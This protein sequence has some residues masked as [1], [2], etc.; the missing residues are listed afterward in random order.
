MWSHLT[1]QP[2]SISLHWLVDTQPPS[3]LSGDG[4]HVYCP[5]P[6]WNMMLLV[7]YE[8]C[9][10]MVLK[11]IKCDFSFALPWSGAFHTYLRINPPRTDTPSNTKVTRCSFPLSF[12]RKYRCKYWGKCTVIKILWKESRVGEHVASSSPSPHSHIFTGLHHLQRHFLK[13]QTWEICWT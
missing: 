7:A 3:P 6:V 10:D 5:R 12:K 1:D 13:P 2:D 8:Q 11:L 4:P 9:C